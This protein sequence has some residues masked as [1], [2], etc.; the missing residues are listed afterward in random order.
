M[1]HKTYLK[2]NLLG[3][4]T[5]ILYGSGVD[6]IAIIGLS[7]YLRNGKLVE[8]DGECGL[9]SRV[10][11]QI[12]CKLRVGLVHRFVPASG[13]LRRPYTGFPR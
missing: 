8:D 4:E 5:L 12:L 7:I 2:E 11:V 1:V 9:L 13:E 10:F 6:M 3:P